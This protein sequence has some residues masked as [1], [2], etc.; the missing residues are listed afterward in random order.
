MEEF[1]L[2]AGPKSISERERQSDK[3]T[4]GAFWTMKKQN[5]CNGRKV[6]IVQS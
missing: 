1:G 3:F 2:Y 6:V 5:K 4:Y